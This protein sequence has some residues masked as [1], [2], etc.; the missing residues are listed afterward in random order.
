MSIEHQKGKDR[1]VFDLKRWIMVKCLLS[2]S[3]LLCV[4]FFIF[5]PSAFSQS[6]I[7]LQNKISVD[8]DGYN[9]E[10]VLRLLSDKY[11]VPIG[12]ERDFLSN[13][14]KDVSINLKAKNITIK[15]LLDKLTQLDSNY[16]WKSVEGVINVTPRSPSKILDITLPTF[17]VTDTELGQV[18]TYIAQ[19]PEFKAGSSQLGFTSST[20]DE[21]DGPALES[22]RVSASMT[23]SNI[24]KILNSFLVK[25]QA[26]F[27]T[28]VPYGVQDRF[29]YIRLY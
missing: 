24:R 3:A 13:P 17:S 5:V 16:E 19:L 28:V 21:Y 27:W 6:P 22:T 2:F 10:R 12:F 29:V 8:L 11:R 14:V 18:G 7:V 25:K 20:A 1:R 23:N 9:I 26:K 4:V 15:D